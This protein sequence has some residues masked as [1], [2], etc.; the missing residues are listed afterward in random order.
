[1]YM[2]LDH[3]TSGCFALG[4][5]VHC[6]L[7]YWPLAVCLQQRYAWSVK[8]LCL[9]DGRHVNA[10]IMS[11]DPNEKQSIIYERKLLKRMRAVA[12]DGVKSV[13]LKL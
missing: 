12:S 7:D 4:R 1:M 6:E 3:V 9:Q 8:L 11:F 10:V 13:R 2:Y 5:D